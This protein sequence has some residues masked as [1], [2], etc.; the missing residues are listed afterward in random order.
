MCP[1]I[2]IVG[3]GGHALSV[4]NVAL[5]NGMSVTA[6]VDDNK[7]GCELLGIQVITKQQCFKVHERANFAIAI[8][9]NSIR[10]RISHE[11]MSALPCAKFPSLI[12]HSAVIGINSKVG[13]GTV[14]MPQVNVGPN[15]TVDSFCIMNTLSSIDHDCEMKSYSSIA[16]GVVTGGN[17]RIGL[18]SAVSIGATIKHKIEIG[19]DAVI[20]ANSY[21]NKTVDNNVFAYGNPCKFVRER[22]KGDAYLS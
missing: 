3:A 10:E 4:A 16:P 14:V 2:I 11:Y 8:G 13:E 20:G 9:D 12:H 7:A 18:R 21:V 6:Y 15:S 19:D 5:G 1:S 22:V 17:V